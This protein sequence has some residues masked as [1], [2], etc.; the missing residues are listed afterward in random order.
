MVCLQKWLP[1]SK[2]GVDS[3]DFQKNRKG[4]WLYSRKLKGMGQAALSRELELRKGSFGP[5][6]K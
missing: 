6:H 5:T 3:I 1:P 2:G 4:G